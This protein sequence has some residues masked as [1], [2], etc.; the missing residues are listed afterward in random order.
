MESRDH[1]D[2]F[3][4]GRVP[5]P[6]PASS[7][8]QYIDAARENSR[9]LKEDEWVSDAGYIADCRI[10]DSDNVLFSFLASVLSTSDVNGSTHKL[11]LSIKERRVE[12]AT[13]S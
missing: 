8:N 5:V 2:E 6:L 12:A 4:H 10:K 13:C 3:S 1:V 9:C 7:I 11:S